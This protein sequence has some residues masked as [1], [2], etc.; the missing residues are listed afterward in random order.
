VTPVR[1]DDQKQASKGECNACDDG[2]HCGHLEGR[3]LSGDQ[4][5]T[6]EQD[7]QE[8]DLGEGFSRLRAHGTGG[9]YFD[10]SKLPVTER[11]FLSSQDYPQG[12]VPGRSRTERAPEQTSG[13][14][15]HAKYDLATICAV[16]RRTVS[17]TDDAL[18][19]LDRIAKEHRST[20]SGVVEAAGRLLRDGGPGADDLKRRLVPDR[21]G[22]DR[23][24]K[25][26]GHRGDR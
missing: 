25:Q 12:A 24:P 18:E 5:D 22:G 14:T 20:V 4:P 6:G 16:K 23:R 9:S 8:S 26:Q 10:Q 11:N 1:R 13:Q 21:R 19:A 15:E 3:D 2:S 7:Q 17:L